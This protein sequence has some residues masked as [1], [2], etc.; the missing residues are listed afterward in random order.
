[1]L[2]IEAT[3]EGSVMLEMALAGVFAAVALAAMGGRKLA[4]GDP[5][6]MVRAAIDE[7]SDLP[8]PWCGSQ[9]READ[10]HCPTCGQRFG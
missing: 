7:S 2:Y 5:T 9:T 3:D 8:C 10:H 6:A 1:M 4:T